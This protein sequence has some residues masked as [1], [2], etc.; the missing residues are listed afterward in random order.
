MVRNRHTAEQ[1]QQNM[2]NFYN[3]L[4]HKFSKSTKKHDLSTKRSFYLRQTI[5]NN[6]I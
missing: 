5:E 2:T 1:N 6:R 4:Q 3:Y